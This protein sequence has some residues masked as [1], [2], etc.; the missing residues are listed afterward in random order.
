MADDPQ[1]NDRTTPH[2]H[3]PPPD[4]RLVTPRS[5]DANG[6]ARPAEAAV[7]QRHAEAISEATETKSSA[8]RSARARRSST[9][10]T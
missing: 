7:A 10:R 8:A 4:A 1:T 5:A 2:E 6:D 3:A 9:S